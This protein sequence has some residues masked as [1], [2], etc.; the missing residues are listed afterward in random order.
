[1]AAPGNMPQMAPEDGEEAENFDAKQGEREHVRG[2]GKPRGEHCGSHECRVGRKRGWKS[3][4]QLVEIF[5]GR[6]EDWWEGD[7]GKK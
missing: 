7:G 4:V 3:V 1:M 5:S 2:G 6:I